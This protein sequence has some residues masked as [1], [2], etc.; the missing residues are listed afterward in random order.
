M[1]IEKINDKNFAQT[2]H[3]IIMFTDGMTYKYLHTTWKSIKKLVLLLFTPTRLS[4]GAYVFYSIGHANM[5][6]NPK[7]KVDQIKHFIADESKLG[8]YDSGSN[9]SIFYYLVDE[10]L[11]RC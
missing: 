4:K 6:G 11:M 7:P 2:Q 9:T 5:G 10:V 1:G 8:E 3:V